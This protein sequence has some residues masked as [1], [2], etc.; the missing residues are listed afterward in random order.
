MK[1]TL[2]LA[3]LAVTAFAAP[4]YAQVD[5]EMAEMFGSMSNVTRPGAHMSQ[6][7]GM[8]TGGSISIRNQIVRP[9]PMVSFDPPKLEAGCGGIDLFGGSLSAVSMPAF[10]DYL[11]AIASNASGYAFQLGLKA[12]A[13]DAE[14]IMSKLGDT[15]RQFNFQM[16]DS[17]QVAQGIAHPDERV[18]AQRRAEMSAMFARTSGAVRDIFSASNPNTGDDA[19]A[20]DYA[21]EAPGAELDITGGNPVWEAMKKTTWF[22]GVNSEFRQDVM[23]LTGTV[24]QCVDDASGCQAQAGDVDRKQARYSPWPASLTLD[25]LVYGTQDGQRVV[26]VLRCNDGDKCLNIREHTPSQ[27]IGFADRLQTALIGPPG[28]PEQGMIRR[29][30]TGEGAPSGEQL[31]MLSAGGAYSGMVLRLAKLDE[32]AAIEFARE[33]S[34]QIAGDVVYSMMG[35]L[36]Q[37]MERAVAMSGNPLAEPA[38]AQIARQMAKLETAN[39]KLSQQAQT[40]AQS[41]AYFTQLA[42]TLAPRRGPEL[43]LDVPTAR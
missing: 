15:V 32:E 29:M 8:I 27:F 37:H 12:I 34:P 14:E 43:A 42:A 7:R 30:R 26:T 21:R 13:P 39:L 40:K 28:M 2:Y 17:C 9:G 6:R 38:G 25:D 16:M 10:K 23:S 18:R 24:V 20:T 22:S 33:F 3:T 19:P 5:R 36:M 31:A 1:W 35:H 41:M 4:A 11:R